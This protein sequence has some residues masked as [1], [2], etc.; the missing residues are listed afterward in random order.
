M[1]VKCL[2]FVFILANVIFPL[3]VESQ[4][5]PTEIKTTK[6]SL[7]SATGA[8]IL[9]GSK[10][11]SQKQEADVN[12]P[13]PV[14]SFES[15]V[16]NLGELGVGEKKKCEFKFKNTGQSL[17]KIERVKVA[18]ACTHPGMSKKA[19][20]PGEEGVI[21]ITY[22]G[23]RKAGF[24]RSHIFVKTND[25]ENSTVKLTMKA[26]VVQY[27]EAV[28][29][30][31]EL[32]LNQENAGVPAVSLKSRDKKP[33]S[34]KAFIV[35]NTVITA[36]FD[37][38]VTA[39]EIVLKPVVD[40]QKLKKYRRGKIKIKVSHPKCKLITLSYEIPPKFQ[41]KPRSI[42]LHNPEPNKPQQRQ[43]LIKS[44]DKK[45]IEIESITSE[46]CD[47]KVLSQE[48]GNNLITLKLEI[49]PPTTKVKLTHF[50]D[51]IIIQMKDGEKLAIPCIG[52]YKS[53]DNKD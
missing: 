28:P 21:K 41:A 32:S 8:N 7:K 46:K 48:P 47:V 23:Q 34:V 3:R 13:S 40:M 50:R 38:N 11:I 24:V 33:F 20:E 49:T 16:R 53:R 29:K 4:E 51:S 14:I 17:L 43:I 9:S 45:P 31:L 6:Q 15:T 5:Q 19:Y 35:S 1:R 39:S 25:T 27:V 2:F 52:L 30:I 42:I 10:E 36:D 37:P 44:K 26:K 18:C 12:M 22:H